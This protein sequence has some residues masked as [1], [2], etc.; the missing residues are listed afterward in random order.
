MYFDDAYKS[1]YTDFDMLVD[2]IDHMMESAGYNIPSAYELE[3]ALDDIYNDVY[4]SGANYAMEGIGGVFGRITG[5]IRQLWSTIRTKISEAWNKSKDKFEEC[6]KKAR[7]KA[8]ERARD[9]VGDLV[10]DANKISAPGSSSETKAKAFKEFTSFLNKFAGQLTNMSGDFVRQSSGYINTFTKLLEASINSFNKNNGTA[11]VKKA[12][13][14][15]KQISHINEKYSGVADKWDAVCKATA[16]KYDKIALAYTKG[17]EFM[18]VVEV[19]ERSIKAGASSVKMIITICDQNDAIAERIGDYATRAT[20]AAKKAG[21]NSNVAGAGPQ[22]VVKAWKDVAQD[23]RSIANGFLRAYSMIQDI[24]DLTFARPKGT[25]GESNL[26][27]A[28]ALRNEY[29]I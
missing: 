24:L 2:N 28:V 8:A 12:E 9:R 3:S 7:E 22:G 11:N 16:A 1:S 4:S 20:D 29:G 27:S 5:A 26:K 18:A 21:D 15:S 25:S 19:C 13:E 14:I 10:D 6:S 23:Y 17:G